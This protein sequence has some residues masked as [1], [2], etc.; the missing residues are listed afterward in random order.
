MRAT[1]KA[2]EGT[3]AAAQVNVDYCRITA[4]VAGRVGVRLVDPGNIVSPSSATGI[5]TLNQIVPTIAVTFTVPQGDFQRLSEASNAFTRPLA[6]Q[7]LS[8]ETGADLGAGELRIADNHVDASTGTVQLKARF[9]E[10]VEVV[11]ARSVR[12]CPADPA[13]LAACDHHPGR[14]GQSRAQG[15]PSPMSSALAIR[16]TVRPIAVLTTQDT[17]AVIKSGL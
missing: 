9:P 13:N 3:V 15:Q 2:D 16:V 1:V 12:Q 5:I 4:P 7:A 11:V 10:P 8:Q 6:V 17:T 14:R